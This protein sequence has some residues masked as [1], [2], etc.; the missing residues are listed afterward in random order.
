MTNNTES[1][2][3]LVNDLIIYHQ[4]LGLAIC[5]PCGI[6]FP[7]DAKCH[8]LKHH[9]MLRPSERQELAQHIQL[10]PERRSFEEIHSNLSAAVE[11][12]E[13]QGLPST[14][15]F[16][17]GHCTF[18]GAEASVKLHCRSH[19]WVVGQRDF[20]F[21]LELIIAPIWFAQWI[22]TLHNAKTLVKYF[23]V[24]KTAPFTQTV[25]ERQALIKATLKSVKEQNHQRHL[26][27]HYIHNSEDGKDTPWIQ[28]TGWK[29]RF[30]G[31]NM[32]DWVKLIDLELGLG[33]EEI[34]ASLH[35]K[36]IQMLELSYAGNSLSDSI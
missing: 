2:N 10:L 4:D 14:E 5:R 36:V 32:E 8:L 31:C 17:C 29:R 6:A 21:V 35:K 18:L 27:H 24:R 19:G 23:P 33:E 7:T 16:K 9:K 1:F 3:K 12:E 13:I 20:H 11:I 28:Y 34:Y 30:E 25:T 22:Q 26:Q 15:A